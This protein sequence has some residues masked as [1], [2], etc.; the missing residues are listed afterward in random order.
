L[1]IGDAVVLRG[2]AIPAA[3]DIAFALGVLLLLGDRVP[4]SLKV[5]LT[6][7]AII[8][9]L[10]AIVVI[11]VFYTE[12]LSTT[13]LGAAV[14]CSAVLWLLNRSR[15]M[16]VEAYVLVGLVMWLFVLKSGVHATLAGVVTALAVP[17]RDGPGR[18]PF[19]AL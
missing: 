16:R 2:W 5:F 10:G 4:V 8:D 3:T 19:L 14:A 13:M 11:A 1:N 7:V 9:D 18:S 6:A 17:M 15:V 12:H